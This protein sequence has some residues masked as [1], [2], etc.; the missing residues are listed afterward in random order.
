MSRIAGGPTG[1][2]RSSGGTRGW[3]PVRAVWLLVGCAAD[4]FAAAAAAERDDAP[5]LELL[6]T[7]R[8]VPFVSCGIVGQYDYACGHASIFFAGN[9]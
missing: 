6:R 5:R 7:P 9:L 4:S 3:S 2:E 8:T 1:T